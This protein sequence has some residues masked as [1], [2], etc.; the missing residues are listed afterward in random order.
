MRPHLRT[1]SSLTRKVR[2]ASCVHERYGCLSPSSPSRRGADRIGPAARGAGRRHRFL[3]GT[4][5]P[6]DR[7]GRARHRRNRRPAR[8][9]GRRA[10]WRLGATTTWSE[11]IGVRSAAAVRRPEAGRPGSRR[12]ADPERG[13]ARRQPVQRLAGGRR[14]A[15]PAGARC[16]DRDRGPGRQPPPAAPTVHHRRAPHRAGARRAGRRHPCA[17][18]QPRGAQ[19]LPEA[20]HA[21]LSGDLHRHGGRDRGNR[22]RPCRLRPDR[23]RRLLAGG[24]A[25]ARRSKR[26]WPAR[27]STHAWPSGS[28]PRISHRSRRSTM[29]AAVRPIAATP[30]S[31]CCAACWRASRHEGRRS[32]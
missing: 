32:P 29:C 24:R 12:P 7:R 22:R 18:A 26:R 15:L 23:G 6:G 21:A 17:A 25:A 3:P 13:H 1:T 11:L 16:R 4:G 8:H 28:R 5:R 2:M 30:S 27:P 10:G 14:R 9:F 31:P 19:R 20:R